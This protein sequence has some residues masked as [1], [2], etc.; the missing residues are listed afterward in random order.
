M[1]TFNI[2]PILK[3]RGIENPYSFL[4]KAG[5]SR[6]SASRIL[7]SHPRVFRLDHIEILCTKLNCTPNDLLS[8]IPEKDT[9]LPENHSLKILKRDDKPFEVYDILKTIS[10]EE[11]NQIADIINKKKEGM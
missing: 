4:V 11:L 7:N 1:L 9:T 3:Q 8:W 10:L 5:I 2:R 6:P